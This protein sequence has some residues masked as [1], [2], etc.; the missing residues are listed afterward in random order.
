MDDEDVSVNSYQ[1]DGKW[2]EENTSRLNNSN[3]LTDYL[4][5]KRKLTE[6]TKNTNDDNQI[7]S[8]CPIVGDDVNQGERHGEGTDQ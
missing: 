8:K 2:R 7:L 5:G 4:L 3:Q 1:K 6:L